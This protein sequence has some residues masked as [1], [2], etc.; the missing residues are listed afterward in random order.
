MHLRVQDAGALVRGAHRLA[1]ARA[2][3]D[4]VQA[5]RLVGVPLAVA[6]AG[7]TEPAAAL[8]RV[9]PA[10]LCVQVA[11]DPPA[12]PARGEACRAAWV[13]ALGAD[14]L[15]GRAVR[16]P[17]GLA[18]AR[19]LFARGLLVH[20]A[21]RDAVVRAEVLG[22]YGAPPRA[23]VAGAVLLPAHDERGRRG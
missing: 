3:R 10:L 17:A 6:H 11:D 13:A 7:G 22:A 23:R 16:Q 18:S 4:L 1:A 9:G 20:A 5:D 15:V 12:A 8:G 21:L 2:R 19:V 14:S